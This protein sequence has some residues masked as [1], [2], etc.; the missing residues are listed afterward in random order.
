MQQGKYHTLKEFLDAAK[1]SYSQFEYLQEA[2]IRNKII[3]RP[4]G[5]FHRS[6]FLELFSIKPKLN[7]KELKGNADNINYD[8]DDIEGF[9]IATEKNEEILLNEV[10]E[11]EFNEQENINTDNILPKEFAEL[12]RYEADKNFGPRASFNKEFAELSSY[13]QG[14]IKDLLDLR[15]NLPKLDP[16]DDLIMSSMN[17]DDEEIC[18]AKSKYLECDLNETE[19]K[20]FSKNI[21]ALIKKYKLPKN[22]YDWLQFYILYSKE[23]PW[24]PLYN[25]DLVEQIIDNPSEAIRI[26]LTTVEKKYI[27]RKSR[28]LLNIKEGRPPKE[29]SDK[30]KQYKALCSLLDKSKNI[31]RKYRSLDNAIK[32]FKLKKEKMSYYDENYQPIRILK[33]YN[34]VVDEIYPDNP[35]PKQKKLVTRLRKQNERFKKRNKLN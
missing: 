13:K 35:K 7:K 19:R 17:Y 11:K 29:V 8:N 34:T 23:P 4:D 12:L 28:E 24:K 6:Q 18:F 1:K 3:K 9:F 22:F 33:D 14:F 10:S 2:D 5:F 25:F 32:V 21:Y 20:K 16:D 31:N 30:Q 27:K 26:P 15:V